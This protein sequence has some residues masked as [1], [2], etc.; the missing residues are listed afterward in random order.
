V[1]RQTDE[2]E[3]VSYPLLYDFDP[4]APPFYRSL[5]VKYIVNLSDELETSIEG[6]MTTH[7][8]MSGVYWSLA[9]LSMILPEEQVFERM[10]K[11][12]ILDWLFTCYDEG[13]GGF[14]GNTYHDAHL[15]FTLSAVQILAILGA[16]EDARFHRERVVEFIASLQLPSGAFVGDLSTT[17]REIDTRFSYCAVCALSLLGGLDAVDVEAAARYVMQC[18]N[19]VDGGFGCTPGAESHA[20]QVF[21]C[22]AALSICQR[23]DL[24]KTKLLAWWLAERQVDSGGLNGRPEKQAD[25]C[26]SW[27]ILSVLSILGTVR[28]ISS[29]HLARFILN[30]QD[31][32]DGGIADRPDDMVDVFHTFFGIAGLSL[33]GH[34]HQEGKP[35]CRQIDPVYALPVDVVRRLGLQAQVIISKIHDDEATDG[36]YYPPVD[37]RLSQY[38]MLHRD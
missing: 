25:V 2:E 38:S 7:L 34:L 33:T 22:V 14:G 30:C 16:L 6:A 36:A 17:I 9:A 12:E 8:K 27:W 35:E 15:L 26:Y 13:T 11:D 4:S 28:Y 37:E 23:L 20:G 21:C 1:E 29:D 32:E 10:K 24:M 31:N 3:D 5:H 18:R 19:A